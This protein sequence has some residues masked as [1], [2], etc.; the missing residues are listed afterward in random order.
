MLTVINPSSLEA[1]TDLPTDA[2]SAVETKVAK[3][4]DLFCDKSRWLAPH[5]RISLL[6]KLAEAMRPL[7]EE[8][9]KLVAQEGGK[10]L[11]DA[12]V[13]ADRA[14][15]G[16][17]LAVHA[18]SEQ[19]GEVIPL[20]MQPASKGLTGIT[21]P[22]PIGPVLAFSAF[23]HPLNLIV[24]Q[25]IPAFAAGCPCIVK[26]AS[27][28]PLS[29]LKLVALMH[30]VGIPAD[31]VQTVIT[32]DLELAG[33]LVEDQRFA[34]FTFI[35]SAKVG[36][37]LRSKL[38]PGTRCAL[39]HGGVAPCFV[40]E[41]A[42]FD[43]AIPMIA[44]GGLYH[45]GQVCVS[46]Q[47][48]FV[49]TAIFDA[50]KA[51]LIEHVKTLKIGSAEDADSDLGPLIRTS[52]VDRVESW[53]DEAMELGATCLLGGKRE[54]KNYFQATL[55]EKVPEKAKLSHAEVFGPV[56][57]L[58]PYTDLVDCIKHANDSP[59]A[60]QASLFSNDHHEIEAFYHHIEAAT[61]LVNRPTAF[62]DDVMPFAGLK[63]SGLGIGGIPYTLH[64]M[65]IQKLLISNSYIK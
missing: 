27:D 63:Q 56:M 1:I 58:Y 12:R 6:K 54:G 42:D 17:E 35:G 55:L 49:H 45:S 18:L 7:K 13:E 9:A 31:Y 20:G 36:W 38:A 60:F 25:I 41:S 14:V 59:F 61:A 52:E 16:V 48:V 64:D 21:R 28:T 23:N 22:H 46:T 57:A 5:E 40:T 26:P 32:E 10:P 2:A 34:F 33:K 37:M 15:Q 53:V 50:F 51:A 4:H 11:K 30:E 24:H 65:Q 62:R 44:K 43:A 8:L 39:E 3:A 29:C 47:R 19:A